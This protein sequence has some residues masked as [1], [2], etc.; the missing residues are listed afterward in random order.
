MRD[1]AVH[2][3]LAAV[4]ASYLAR[5]CDKET[6]KMVEK[7]TK[8]FGLHLR[9]NPLDIPAFTMR[10]LD[11]PFGTDVTPLEI[12]SSSFIVNLSQDK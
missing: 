2:S 8:D 7:R 3:S 12:V 6:Q 10:D 4:H 1:K 11:V 5:F 9:S